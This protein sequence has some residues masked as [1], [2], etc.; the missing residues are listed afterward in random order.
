MNDTSK[1]AQKVREIKT[2]L[3]DE[4]RLQLWQQTAATQ[5]LSGEFVLAQKLGQ[6]AASEEQIHMI[7]EL[8][9]R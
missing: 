1:I 5:G 4:Q 8:F 3:S 6:E 9:G 2:E 7:S